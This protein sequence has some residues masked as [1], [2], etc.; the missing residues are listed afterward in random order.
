MLGTIKKSFQKLHTIHMN[1]FHQ[2]KA[3]SLRYAFYGYVWWMN[4]YF[5]TPI[6]WRLSSWALKKKTH[7]LD[8][9]L[10]TRY[11]SIYAE[12]KKTRS[13]SFETTENTTR[14]IWVFWGQGEENMPSLV[15]ACFQQL[16]KNNPEVNLVTLDNYS[17]YLDLPTKIIDRVRKKELTWAFFSDVL[18]TSLLAVH[19]GLW[20]DATVWVPGKLPW[21][22]LERLPF[23]SA[24]GEVNIQ[25]HSVCF[26]TSLAH[27]WSRWCMYARKKPSTVCFFQHAT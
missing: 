25:R 22:K 4:F 6:S 13:S 23:F 1:F 7:W 3:F 5:R 14:K 10:S 17:Q 9:Y 21:E 19:G 11:S 16:Q 2:A 26:W 18:R 12:A 24:N 15:K 20:L 27:N 8:Q